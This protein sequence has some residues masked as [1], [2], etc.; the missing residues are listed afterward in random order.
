MQIRKEIDALT[1]LRGVAAFWVVIYHVHY[2]DAMSGPV[3]VLLRH[4]YLA[5]DIFFILSGFVMALSYRDL[6]S[7][8]FAIK[9][10][11]VFMMRRFARVYPLYFVATAAC[12][13][14]HLHYSSGEF[15]H[16]LLVDIAFNLPLMQSW[17]FAHPIDGPSWS[18]STEWAAYLLFPAL[19]SFVFG[20]RR[21]ALLALLTALIVMALLPMLPTPP[22]AGPRIGPLNIPWAKSIWPLVRCLAEFTMGLV[23]LRAA[24]SA[25]VKR[26]ISLPVLANLVAAGILGLLLLE[27]SDVVVVAMIP[28]LILTLVGGKGYTTHLLASGPALFLG[29]ISYAVYLVHWPLLRIRQF[30]RGHFTRLLGPAG[31]DD[32]AL[33]IFYGALV[34]IA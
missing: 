16:P 5:V 10:Q 29:R 9:N 4:G 26:Y 28:L 30:G 14:V 17:G 12:V 19:A 24:H 31:A 7:A 18:V 15:G 25:V 32:A 11:C 2:L 13:L 8:A 34:S 1:G 27:G 21:S 22:N 20:K 6:F 23:T 3:A 33:V